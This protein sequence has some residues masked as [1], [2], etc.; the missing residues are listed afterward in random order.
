MSPI[1]SNPRV[2]A[3]TLMHIVQVRCVP[4]FLHHT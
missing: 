2:D 3:S 4:T 1:F